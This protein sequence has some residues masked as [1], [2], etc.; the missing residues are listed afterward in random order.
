MQTFLR[1]A[2]R[3]RPGPPEEGRGAWSDH[4]SHSGRV[5]RG[6]AALHHHH[7]TNCTRI[8]SKNMTTNTLQVHVAFTMATAEENSTVA[9]IKTNHKAVEI[10]A[11]S[12]TASKTINLSRVRQVHDGVNKMNCNRC[13]L[14]AGSVRRDF[15]L[16]EMLVDRGL[17]EEVTLCRARSA[18]LAYLCSCRVGA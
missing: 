7:C 6:H 4:R 16:S 11:V 5:S 15:E 14:Q 9:I 10:Q 8:S 1:I 3:V 13:R 18:H 2:F 12:Q 17:S